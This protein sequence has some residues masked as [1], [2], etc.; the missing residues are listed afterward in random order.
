MIVYLHGFS[1]GAASQKAVKLKRML[2]PLPMII[3]EYP[4]H[5][6]SESI[7]LLTQTINRQ[8]SGKRDGK[9]MLI[10]SSLGGYFAQYLAATMPVVNG[11]VLINPALQPQLTLQ[12]YIGEQTNMVTGEPF[13]LRQQDLEEL[14]QFE[15]PVHAVKVPSLMLLDE[16]DEVID[17]RYAS[18]RYVSLG[19]VIVYPGGSHWFDHLEAAVPEI[20]SFYQSLDKNQDAT[21]RS[22]R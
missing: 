19:R 10:G 8:A 12:P 7:A 11:V 22:L 3:P 4:S 18:N 14:A 9:I 20:L 16:G 13:E 2:A 21:N 6:P 1:S 17:Y 15:V 5:R